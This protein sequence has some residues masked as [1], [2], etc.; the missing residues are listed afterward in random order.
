[1]AHFLGYTSKP[2]CRSYNRQTDTRPQ[3]T[4]VTLTAPTSLCHLPLIKDDFRN[5]SQ[6]TKPPCAKKCS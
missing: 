1:M 2:S 5:S 3:T 4:A 6:E